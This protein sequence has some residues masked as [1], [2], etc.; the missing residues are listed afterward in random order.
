MT[1]FKMNEE[2]FTGSQ[3]SIFMGDVWID[4]ILDWQCSIGANATPI[5]GYGQTFFQHA[6]QGRVLVQGSF[7]INFK[8]PNYI[9]AALAK[10]KVGQS[11]IR[12]SNTPFAAVANITESKY[13]DKRKTLD[14]FFYQDKDT[15]IFNA[16]SQ[17]NSLD[18]ESITGTVYNNINEKSRLLNIEGISNT[19]EEGL[20]NDFAVPLF[21]I[22]IGYGV[23]LDSNTI[24]EKI[25]GIKLIGKG[26]VIMANGEPIKET[27][28][29]FARNI[30]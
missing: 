3:A 8:E 7:T 4:D 11:A 13:E 5:Y 6:A 23:Q 10:Y 30:V 1:N 9:F 25:L 15:G 27:Y 24:G 29:F 26:K 12:S 18:D 21:D 17:R 22:K 16:R 2:Y 28:N 20:H 14:D 19:S